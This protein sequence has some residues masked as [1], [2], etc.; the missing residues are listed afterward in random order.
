MAQETTPWSLPSDPTEAARDLIRTNTEIQKQSKILTA[1]RQRKKS[2]E[3]VVQSHLEA[4]AEDDL[5]VD[6]DG[7]IFTITRTS[8]A[9]KPSLNSD[10]VEECLSSAGVKNIGSVMGAIEKKRRIKQNVQTK[11]SVVRQR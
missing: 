2:L 4:N 11:L 6:V 3:G 8:H 1:M 9:T 5:K 10:L 7:L